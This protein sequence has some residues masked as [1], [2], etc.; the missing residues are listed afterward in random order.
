MLD[1]YQTQDTVCRRTV[2]GGGLGPTLAFVVRY[3]LSPRTHERRMTEI[4]S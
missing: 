4:V 1:S 3:D 2:A